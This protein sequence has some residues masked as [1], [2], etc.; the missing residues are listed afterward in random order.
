MLVAQTEEGLISLAQRF[1]L[2]QLK[3]WKKEKQFYCP[4]CQSPVQLKAGT[5]KS[6][7]LL[8]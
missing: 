4:S 2:E 7:I 8:T 6:L 1:S 5:K 3:L